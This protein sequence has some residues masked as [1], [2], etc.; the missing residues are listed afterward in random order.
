MYSYLRVAD[1]GGID[2]APY[3][4]VVRW[5]ANVESLHGFIP[6]TRSTP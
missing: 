6:M 3:A 2:L 4:A 5:L 1:E